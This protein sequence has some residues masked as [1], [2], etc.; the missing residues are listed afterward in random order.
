M[1]YYKDANLLFIHIPK[2]GGTSLEGYLESKYTQTIHDSDKHK[3]IPIRKRIF[4]QHYTYEDIYKYREIFE[5][6]FNNNL[7]IITI[8]R[9]PYDR[10]ISDLFYL[11]YINND[12]TPDTIYNVIKNK[13]LY[14]EDLYNHNI[15]QYKFV[16]DDK[17]EIIHNLK[18]F[19]TESLTK[20]LKEYGYEDYN[21]KESSTDY[22]QYLNDDSIKLIN[23]FYKTD[24]ELFNYD[25]KK[26]ENFENHEDN[27]VNEDNDIYETFGD[28][29][30]MDE[31]G[32]IC[33]IEY[34]DIFRYIIIVMLIVYIIMCIVKNIKF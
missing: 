16:I 29:N 31:S 27:F 25:M 32:S 14:E 5:V 3:K 24:F 9:N 8:V 10:I 18:I 23:E 4:L 12:D 22:S 11:R 34:I 1:P 30:D 17:G 13:Y 2:T 20:E 26:T 7:N 33:G 6:N 28:M 21:G 19:K 15:P